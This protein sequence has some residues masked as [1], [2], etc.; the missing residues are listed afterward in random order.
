[1]VDVAAP[2][3]DTTTCRDQKI[4]LAKKKLEAIIIKILNKKI[5]NKKK[6]PPLP[7]DRESCL[8]R[9]TTT[10][11]VLDS[12]RQWYREAIKHRPAGGIIDIYSPVS[13]CAVPDYQRY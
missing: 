6:S 13:N 3:H 7:R 9:R 1:V 11:R 2:I 8:H 5:K 12:S 4:K 10:T